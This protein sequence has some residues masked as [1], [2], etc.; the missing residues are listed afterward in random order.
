MGNST[1]YTDRKFNHTKISMSLKKGVK[2]RDF[3]DVVIPIPKVLPP[4]D[5]GLASVV[6]LWEWHYRE[7][8]GLG[9]RWRVA[10]VPLATKAW[11]SA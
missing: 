11:F 7:G 1:A 2:S 4:A 6:T 8:G 3:P 5:C 9:C 10:A